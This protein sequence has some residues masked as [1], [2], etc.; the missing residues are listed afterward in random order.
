VFV[1]L[2]KTKRFIKKYAGHAFVLSLPITAILCEKAINN[3]SYDYHSWY[4]FVQFIWNGF[5]LFVIFSSFYNTNKKICE[6]KLNA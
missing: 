1:V 4:A 3:P 5:T 2:W 6:G